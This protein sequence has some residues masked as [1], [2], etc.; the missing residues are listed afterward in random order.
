MRPESVEIKVTLAG[1]N[2][3]E[4]VAALGLPEGQVWR[5]LFCED[6]TT[7]VAPSTPLL[8]IGV[9]LRARK[10]SGSKGDSTVKLRPC[11]WSQLSTDFFAN[12]ENGSAELKIEADWAGPKRTLA[13]S[14]TTD[15]DDDRVTA[16]QSGDRT[17]ADLFDQ[18][19][20]R[21]LKQCSSGR[22]NLDAL[23][24]LA[25][26]TATRWKEFPAKVAGPDLSVRAERWVIDSAID[27]LELSIV[28]DLA[29][30]ERD[31]TALQYFVADHSLIVE[32]NQENK[33]QRL[34]SYL[35]SRSVITA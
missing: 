15:W 17:P 20:R 19:Q 33:T 32:Q 30:A 26:I 24:A 10:K 23:T 22:V 16:V 28:S 6:V 1:G 21:F 25:D 5:I 35:V 4:A 13:A 11:R 14:L 3:G 7:G 27:F 29:Q 31:Q 12:R 8:D 18:E 2:V 34:L 9:V